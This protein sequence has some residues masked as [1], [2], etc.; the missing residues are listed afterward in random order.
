MIARHAA[1]CAGAGVAFAGLD[2]VWLTVTNAALYRPIPHGVLIDG[3]RLAPA[4]AFYLVF[5]LGAMVFAVAPGLAVGRCWAVTRRGAMFGVF[6]Y[7][8]HDLANQAA[9]AVWSTRIL[10]LDRFW[11][12]F[13][14]AVGA[15]AVLGGEGG[16]GGRV[17]SVRGETANA[18]A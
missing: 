5:P 16:E 18:A 17:R 1:A 15:T 10:L 9:L 6:A 2:A 11:G 7:A 4:V 14:T 12:T 13:V 8:T 3:I